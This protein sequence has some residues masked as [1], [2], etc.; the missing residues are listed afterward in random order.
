MCRR[1]PATSQSAAECITSG[2]S[3]D[4][5]RGAENGKLFGY[6]MYTHTGFV[7]IKREEYLLMFALHRLSLWEND[8]PTEREFR[9]PPFFFYILW[10]TNFNM[11]SA[12]STPCGM[13]WTYGRSC[14]YICTEKRSWALYVVCD[15]GSSFVFFPHT[16]FPFLVDSLSPEKV[17][18]GV[19]SSRWL[20][21]GHPRL[22]SL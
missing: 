22:V 8:G 1:W 20:P 19:L 2:V 15:E 16:S 9:F 21:K 4:G 5:K 17:A 6:L 11:A 13:L 3:D 18:V 10:T 14:S 7:A 12:H